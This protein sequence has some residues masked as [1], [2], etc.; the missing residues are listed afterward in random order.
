MDLAGF[1]RDSQKAAETLGVASRVTCTVH[2]P[3]LIALSIDFYHV[4]YK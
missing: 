1:S 3:R 2:T 4:G